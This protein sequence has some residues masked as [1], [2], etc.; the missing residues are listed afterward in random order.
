M[1]RMSSGILAVN[2]EVAGYFEMRARVFRVTWRLV[3]EGSNLEE[4]S[5]ARHGPM[6]PSSKSLYMFEALLLPT[7]LP[8]TPVRQLLAGR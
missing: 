3:L 8:L 5:S 6:C 4:F 7:F 2:I 1:L